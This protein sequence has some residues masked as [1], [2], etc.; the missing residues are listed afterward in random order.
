MSS[1]GIPKLEPLG[2]IGPLCSTTTW[3]C[4]GLNGF[5][6][7]GLVAAPGEPGLR[8][9]TCP[10]ARTIRQP[11]NGFG[12]W[13]RPGR[14]TGRLGTIVMEN[15]ILV[16]ARPCLRQCVI[17]GI[18]ATLS[19]CGSAPEEP[20]V[21]RSTERPS[22][23][24][25]RFEEDWS[26][27]RDPALRTDPLD[28][29]KFIPLDQSGANYLSLGGEVRERYEYT[30]NPVWGDDPQDDHGV[31]LQRYIL[32]GDLH[33]GKH[34]RLFTELY[35]ALE[36]G[37]AGPAS[38]VDENELDLQQAFLDL[39]AP[40]GTQD[41]SATLRVGRQEMRFGSARLIDV[42]EGPNVRRKFDGGRLGLALGRWQV[43]GLA[44]R[45]AEIEPGVFDDGFDNEQELWGIYAVGTPA[46]LPSGSGF[47]VYY[48]GYHNNFGDYDQGVADETRHTVGTRLWA[49]RG[50]WDWNWELAGQWG[51][52]GSGDIRAWTIASDTGYT[53]REAPWAPRLGLSANI[54]SGDD[55]PDDND[56]GTFNP[57]FPRGSY[58][59]E[60]ALLGPRNFFNIHPFLTVN[61]HDDLS[62][63]AD[64]DFFWR[65]ETGDGI[66]NPGGQL[67]RSGEG[68]DARHVGNELSLNATWQINPHASFTAIYAHFFPGNFVENTGSAEDIDFIELT[69]KILF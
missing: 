42:R 68:T 66:Y 22:Y 62:L 55:D 16:A 13:L 8:G 58:F 27:L 48:L 12:V 26:V 63:T 47:D 36:D 45:P 33:L 14:L 51:Q 23:E 2:L 19:A 18:V 41:G 61:P 24:N 30:H 59:S 44:V 53:W 43:D 46:W 29:V 3:P 9:P 21:S 40:L 6:C 5:L 50:G 28:P 25:L 69:L 35:S 11:G 64:F 1:E 34:V 56:L 49:E 7:L 20:I 54:A 31:I 52:F 60:L 10:F 38:P 4:S 39:G 65:L 32:H 57:L 15:A 37:R 67:L 17:A